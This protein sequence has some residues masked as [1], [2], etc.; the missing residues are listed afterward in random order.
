M[1]GIV[2][3]KAGRGEDGEREEGNSQGKMQEQS[4]L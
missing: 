2:G 3:F 1:E 4:T